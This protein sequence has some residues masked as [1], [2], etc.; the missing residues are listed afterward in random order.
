MDSLLSLPWNIEVMLSRDSTP[1]SGLQLRLDT[2][3]DALLEEDSPSAG[4][5]PG[6]T[7]IVSDAARTWAR[8][9]IS[10][11]LTARPSFIAHIYARR[12]KVGRDGY[13]TVSE[14]VIE[15]VMSV[16]L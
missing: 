9:H 11:Y 13:S 5:A 1:T 12:K 6:A 16:G 14:N 10:Q 3:V 8:Q 2:F 4:A 15:P 7:K